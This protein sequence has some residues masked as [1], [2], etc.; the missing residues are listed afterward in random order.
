MFKSNK[1]RFIV[2]SEFVEHKRLKC[3]KQYVDRARAQP[4]RF[5]VLHREM[6]QMRAM[7][8]YV[9]T[10]SKRHPPGLKRHLSKE[11]R[12]LNGAFAHRQGRQPAE[13]RAASQDGR[14][15]ARII[16]G[17][18]TLERRGGGRC[19]A[20]GC[21]RCAPFAITG[22]TQPYAGPDTGQAAN[23]IH[24]DPARLVTRAVPWR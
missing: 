11:A 14:A 5:S 10:A 1:Y 15:N 3:R 24:S 21:P 20:Y 13:D 16:H 12:T 7:R 4:A 23:E 19:S 2:F 9:L 22:Q 18:L 6:S 17:I 8:F